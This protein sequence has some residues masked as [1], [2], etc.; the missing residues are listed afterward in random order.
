MPEIC[1]TGLTRGILRVMSAIDIL[2]PRER[3]KMISQK[4]LAEKAGLHVE[5]VKRHR[6]MGLIRGQ[7]VGLRKVMFEP[8]E[9][10]RYL[11]L[12]KDGE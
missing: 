1:Q 4:E 5:T 11:G 3:A 9:A 12:Q 7:R 6:K 10:A 8:E 2:T